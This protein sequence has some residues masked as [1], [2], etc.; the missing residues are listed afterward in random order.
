MKISQEIHSKIEQKPFKKVQV[1]K[2]NFEQLVQ[3]Q[4]HKMK[5]QELEKLMQNITDQGERLARFRSFQDLAKFKRMIKQFL[6]E[7]VYN[8]YQLDESTSFNPNSFTHKMTTVK[9]IDEK[10]IQLT[11]D[12]LD[13]EKQT[14]DLLGVI[15]EIKGLLI[16][17]Y[18]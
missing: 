5:Q 4:S 11:N 12:L 7:T 14:V 15:G 3:S 8:G 16:N 18:T 6:E 17:L 9:E 10:L 13:Q 1:G 2:Q